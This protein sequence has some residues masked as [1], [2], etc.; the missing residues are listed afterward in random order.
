MLLDMN[1]DLPGRQHSGFK[2][3]NKMKYSKL[4][5][6]SSAEHGWWL[7]SP[8]NLHSDPVDAWAFT[9][10]THYQS[11]DTIIFPIKEKGETLD[12]TFFAFGY[13]VMRNSKLANGLIPQFRNSVQFIPAVASDGT[14]LYIVNVLNS[15]DCIDPACVNSRYPSIY[16]P[17]SKAGKPQMVIELRLIQNKIMDLPIFRVEGWQIPIIISDELIAHI[18]TQKLTGISGMPVSLK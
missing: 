18:K 2:V 6:D 14:E 3:K 9:T 4:I 1:P 10:G 11:D 12:F 8:T 5:P 15:I 13:L 17:R 16:E 7:G